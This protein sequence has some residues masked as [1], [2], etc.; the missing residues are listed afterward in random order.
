[1]CISSMVARGLGP[2]NIASPSTPAHPATPSLG[3]T[4]LPNL[5]SSQPCCCP[6]QLAH[7]LETLM[8][9]A[10]CTHTHTHTFHAN[11]DPLTPVEHPQ[12]ACEA[13]SQPLNATPP[14]AHLSG[15]INSPSPRHAITPMF[16]IISCAVPLPAQTKQHSSLSMFGLFG[17]AG[18]A[19]FISN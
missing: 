5:A 7:H 3:L 15:K 13:T 10:P 12:Q 8:K 19:D 14:L 17:F 18:V 1:M 6:Q 4:Q 9:A 11:L 16:L 2:T